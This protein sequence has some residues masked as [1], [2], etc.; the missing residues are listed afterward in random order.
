M[1]NII[2]EKDRPH[3]IPLK[4]IKKTQSASMY[5]G[6]AKKKPQLLFNPTI[7][8]PIRLISLQAVE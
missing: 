4:N 6:E 3:A 8:K 2:E 7:K 5:H 1:K